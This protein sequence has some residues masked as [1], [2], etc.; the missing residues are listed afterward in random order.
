[1]L[2]V[3]TAE[4][5]DAAAMADLF[6]EMDRFYDE[7]TI[8]P[9]GTKTHQIESVL[10]ATPP[11]AYALLA[12]DGPELVGIAAYS[13]LWPAALT[14][15]SLYLKELY[16]R[17]QHRRKG[18]GRLL[19]QYLFKVARDKECSRVEWT[20]DESNANA[21]DFYKDLGV[22]VNPSKVFYRIEIESSLTS[23]A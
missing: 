9:A 2:T 17:Q 10:F 18:V 22:Q 12:W 15:K 11:P 21:Q 4:P 16:V 3:T 19:M 6:L 1:M 13:F 20:T 14:S 7:I 8:E 23:E 5:R